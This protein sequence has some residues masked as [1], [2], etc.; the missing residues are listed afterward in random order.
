MKDAGL[1]G[2]KSNLNKA[3]E[4]SNNRLSFAYAIKLRNEGLTYNYIATCL[5]KEGFRT[6][7]GGGW[8]GSAVYK[9]IK[10]FNLI[11]TI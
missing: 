10:R 4:H 2:A 8:R 3:L 1:K 7:T 5:N 9:L 11:T 6:Q